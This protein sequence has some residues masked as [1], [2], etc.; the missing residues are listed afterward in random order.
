MPAIQMHGQSLGTEW[1]GLSWVFEKSACFQ[2]SH[3]VW[4]GEGGVV[5]CVDGSV[6]VLLRFVWK[7]LSVGMGVSGWGRG[8]FGVWLSE[9]WTSG[10]VY[11]L[12]L[13]INMS[14]VWLIQFGQK[15]NWLTFGKTP[16]NCPNWLDI[17]CDKSRV[18]PETI[19]WG[20]D[21]RKGSVKQL[22]DSLCSIHL[23]FLSNNCV[24]TLALSDAQ[25]FCPQLY[26]DYAIVWNVTHQSAVIFG[27]ITCPFKNYLLL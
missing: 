14:I 24:R 5:V 6:G 3:F 19:I 22:V 21:F 27:R 1:T 9:F 13:T 17:I 18:Q 15:V 20:P 25:I 12:I 11:I 7:S 2:G 10:I 26:N 16:F 4:V 8:V 23:V